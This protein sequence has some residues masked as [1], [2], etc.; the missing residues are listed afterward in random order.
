VELAE[1]MAWSS[2]FDEPH[3]YRSRQSAD[4]AMLIRRVKDACSA[5]GVQCVGTSATMATE[6]SSD[7][8]SQVVAEVTSLIFGI[9]ETRRLRTPR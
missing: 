5:R 6:G 1:P 2:C 8:Q 9:Q 3:T 4:V 7:D